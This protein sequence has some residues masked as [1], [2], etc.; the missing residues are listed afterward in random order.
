M[1]NTHIRPARPEDLPAILKMIKGLAS[2][3]G[4]TAE[5]SLAQLRRDMTGPAPWITTLVAEGPEGLQGY[6]ALLPRMILQFGR[7]GMD[8]HH[9]FVWPDLRGQGI[10][11][12]LI[13]AA[14]ANAEAA[15]CSFITVGTDPGNSAAQQI[16]LA[17]G[18]EPLGD[19]GP[20][21]RKKLGADAA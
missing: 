14:L 12:A 20:R 6:V 2:F 16:Y 15:D 17:A 7:R 21:F 1:K 18:F 19:T 10:G 8:L 9:L 13:A 3:H 11:G 5:I 4:D